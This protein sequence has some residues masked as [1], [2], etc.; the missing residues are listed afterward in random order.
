[1]A[2]LVSWCYYRRDQEALFMIGGAGSSGHSAKPVPSRRARFHAALQHAQQGAWEVLK[3][4]S[5]GL[6]AAP[7]RGFMTQCSLRICANS[8]TISPLNFII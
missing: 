1:M 7:Y 5:Y 2:W 4:S 3:E 6:F 8:P